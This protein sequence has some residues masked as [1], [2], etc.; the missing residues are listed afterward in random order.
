M[1]NG[2]SIKSNLIIYRDGNDFVLKSN[3]KIITGLEVYDASG[4]LLIQLK[5]NQKETRIDASAFVNGTYVLRIDQ[6][7]TLVTKKIIK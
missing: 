3:S 5:P 4:R 1:S 2:S 6:E 7:G